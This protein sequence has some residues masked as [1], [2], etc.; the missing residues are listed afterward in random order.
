M[1][2]R[3]QLINFLKTYFT[4]LALHIIIINRSYE[5]ICVEF[6]RQKHMGFLLSPQVLKSVMTDQY[7]V[8]L[9]WYMINRLKNRVQLSIYSTRSLFHKYNLDS[10]VI[11][12]WHRVREV[13]GSIPSQRPRHTKD[14]IKTS[15]VYNWTLKGEILAL[16]QELR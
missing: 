12:C 7:Y 4:K 9:V 13:P 3:S 10:L 2:F 5:A 11:E 6:K 16:S 8:S 14:V 1:P 15:L